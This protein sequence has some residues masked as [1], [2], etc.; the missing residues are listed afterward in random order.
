[1]KNLFSTK[2]DVSRVQLLLTFLLSLSLVLANILTIKQFNYFGLRWLT[3]TCGVILFP[4]TYI[5][6]DVFSEVYGYKWSR[7]TSIYALIGCILTTIAFKITILI[8]GAASWTSQEA[9]ESILGSS[10]QI[11]FASLLAFFFGDWANDIVYKVLKK[12]KASFGVKAILSS[13]VGK[14]VDGFIFTFIGLS[15]LPIKDKFLLSIESPWIQIF[16]EL[17]FLPL[18]FTIAKKLKRAENITGD[19]EDGS[20]Q[21]DE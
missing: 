21:K 1:M 8:P 13:I 16:I 5:L 15:F 6:S 14:T 10:F 2:K 9:L 20:E 17:I 7:L 19:D 4:F 18:T 12:K 3:S 11:T